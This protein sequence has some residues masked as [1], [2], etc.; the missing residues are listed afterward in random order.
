MQII[1]YPKRHSLCIR[2]HT[3]Y[4]I[5]ISR[6]KVISTLSKTSTTNRKSSLSAT[7]Y[8]TYLSLPATFPATQPTRHGNN[9]VEC[10]RKTYIFNQL[11]WTCLQTH[12]A[13]MWTSYQK[14]WSYIILA[15]IFRNLSSID[16]I[17]KEFN[18]IGGEKEHLTSTL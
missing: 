16:K 9:L 2:V 6:L 13:D 8:Q 1:R 14:Y 3:I 11:A 18:L 15:F 7:F 4:I 10:L 5:Q 12:S 17:S